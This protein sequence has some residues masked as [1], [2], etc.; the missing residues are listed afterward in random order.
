MSRNPE[1]WG[2][3]PLTSKQRRIS[4]GVSLAVALAVMWRTE[5]LL[6]GFVTFLVVGVLVNA[7]LYL[8]RPRA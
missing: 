5:N 1:E 7:L 6:W 2:T 3:S 4:T 8:R